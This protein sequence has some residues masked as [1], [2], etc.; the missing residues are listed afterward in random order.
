M[1]NGIILKNVPD[2]TPKEKLLEASY[3]AAA[4][5][6]YQ[7]EQGSREYSAADDVSAV[8][9]VKIGA[10]KTFSDLLSG[11][12]NIINKAMGRDTSEFEQRRDNEAA[13][14]AE[15]QAQ[16]PKSSFVGQALPYLATAGLGGSTVA[17]QAAFGAG[18]GLLESG[19]NLTAGALGGG[20]GAGGALA[21]KALGRGVNALRGRYGAPGERG[22]LRVQE[23]PAYPAAVQ[24]EMPGGQT[25]F[26]R[27]HENNQ[28]VLK[29]RA[30]EMIG[31]EPPAVVTGPGATGA[32]DD[33][34]ESARNDLGQMFE[35]SLGNAEIT[36]GD[37][38]IDN[39]LDAGT[40]TMR[41]A[42]ETAQANGGRIPGR[43]AHG[44]LQ[45]LRR[46]GKAS[47]P[48]VRENAWSMT[49]DLLGA[50]ENGQGIDLDTFR[51]AQQGW[52]NLVALERGSGVLQQSGDI[53]ANKLRT[54]LR[55]VNNR[56]RP[57]QAAA[58]AAYD[59][60]TEV[61]ESG[62]EQNWS[63]SGRALAPAAIA[64]AAA[65]FNPGMAAAAGAMYTPG[66]LARILQATPEHAA[67][68]KAGGALGR[69][70]MPRR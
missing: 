4:R 42:A 22:V 31:Q 21:G 25:P 19:G 53:S 52:K 20:F 37:E 50:M 62:F 27:I 7:A 39:M 46:L 38:L 60:A 56:R 40:I 32:W 47:E 14:F 1:P 66:V 16:R 33:V 68:A 65:P 70:G 29:S 24:Q 35:Q 63:R 10:G 69:A 44:A 2:G 43:E 15:L 17:G 59:T 11:G 23:N 49:D 58:R 61:G 67:F 28:G 51:Q 6:A 36:I 12:A 57:N 54:G 34:L 64:A 48:A 45:S 41:R 8:D 18:A 13:G 55:A 9:A 26:A 30:A 3:R 5:N